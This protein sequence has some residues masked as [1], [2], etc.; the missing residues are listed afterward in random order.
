[1]KITSVEI[2]PSGSIDALVLSFRDPKRINEYNV[3]G[4]V[5]LDADEIVPRYYG[6][7]GTQKY[8]TLSMEKRA[9]AIQV[10]F[11]PN[12]QNESSFSSL[13][14]RLYK[15]IASSRTGVIE[16]QFKNG[17]EVVA[18]VSGFVSKMEN[19]LFDKK[20]GCTI[21]VDCL[22]PMLKA[23]TRTEIDILG[24]DPASSN[25]EDTK[26]TAPHGFVFELGFLAD[27]ASLTMTPP[28]DAW[29]F[30][31][32]PVGGFLTGDILHFS[33]ELNSKYLYVHRGSADIHLADVVAPG[34][35]WPILFPGD[36]VFEIASPTSVTWEAASYYPTYWGV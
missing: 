15:M 30:V 10:E 8:Y 34:S 17:T 22:E 12:F 16:V 7:S 23:P 14:D 32:T 11:N 26:S 19:T 2:H 20:P 27:L 9:I 31:I 29:S 5:G 3:K 25:I 21:S 13:R 6:A 36:N 4:I 18:T 35:V 1:M 33:S 24:L 28:D